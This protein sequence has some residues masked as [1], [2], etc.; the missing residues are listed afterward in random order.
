MSDLDG[1]EGV[2][3]LEVAGGGEEGGDYGRGDEQSPGEGSCRG[4]QLV[5]FNIKLQKSLNFKLF[6]FKLSNV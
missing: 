4:L 3:Y 6:M 2:A 1:T 5:R